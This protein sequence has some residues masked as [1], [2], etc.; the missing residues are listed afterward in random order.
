V[1]AHQPSSILEQG[2]RLEKRQS[3]YIL[4]GARMVKLSSCFMPVMTTYFPRN[5]LSGILTYP[6]LRVKK[7]IFIEI[8]NIRLNACMGTIANHIE[9]QIL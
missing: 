9:K 6:P 8:G 1:T 2:Q 3:L 5:Y 4:K 7:S